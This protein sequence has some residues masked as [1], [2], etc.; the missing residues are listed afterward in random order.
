MHI[1]K[2]RRNRFCF[3][4]WTK[5]LFWSFAKN[6]EH[7]E[8]DSEIDST[9]SSQQ[10]EHFEIEDQ[11]QFTRLRTSFSL[12]HITKTRKI[13]FSFCQSAKFLFWSFAKNLEHEVD[14]NSENPQVTILSEILRF[15]NSSPA[16]SLLKGIIYY[17]SFTSDL[18][19]SKY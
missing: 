18:S 19:L 6:L 12:M 9:Q 11:K 1:T 3:S 15:Q 8:E 5:L 2:T 7:Q 16:S 17:T 4:E 13:G 14:E 10:S